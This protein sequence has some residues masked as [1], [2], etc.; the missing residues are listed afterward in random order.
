MMQRWLKSLLVIVG[1]AIVAIAGFSLLGHRAP[2]S[3]PPLARLDTNSFEPV[4]EAFNAGTD[5]T[6]VILLLSPT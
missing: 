2:A 6:R 3:Q 4:R 1:V 5:R